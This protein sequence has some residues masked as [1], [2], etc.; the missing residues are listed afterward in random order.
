MIQKLIC[1]IWGHKTF[2]K[3]EKKSTEGM[4]YISRYDY[5]PRCGTK[6]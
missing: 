5:C 6:L 1:K 3:N 2:Y 4:L